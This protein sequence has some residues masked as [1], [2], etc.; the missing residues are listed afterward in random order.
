[1]KDTPLDSHQLLQSGSQGDVIY[2]LRTAHQNQTQLL[3]LA[4]QKANILIGAVVVAL[5]IIFAR[6]N[7][8][9]TLNSALIVPFGLFLVL[10]LCAFVLALMVITPSVSGRAKLKRVSDIP[11]PLFFGFFTQFKEDE[12]V[13]YLC[14][15]LHNNDMA[16]RLLAADLYQIGCVLKKK[17]KVLK[18][19]YISAAAGIILPLIPGTI[20]FL[21]QT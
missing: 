18:Y 20:I 4:D 2:T 19:A 21:D 13:D 5:T 3:I 9:T 15:K 7:L 1:M 16:R 12:Y 14:D 11:N 17:Y 8:M 6:S 10:E